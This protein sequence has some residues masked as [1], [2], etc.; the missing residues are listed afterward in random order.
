[1][2]ALGYLIILV[3]SATGGP[4][5]PEG[6]FRLGIP[7]QACMETPLPEVHLPGD[8]RPDFLGPPDA[9]RLSDDEMGK[10]KGSLGVPI[11]V[12]YPLPFHGQYGREAAPHCFCGCR[13]PASQLRS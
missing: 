3:L 10:D 9:Q 1:M 11:P 4:A 7:H 2:I 6:P 12:N 5:L 13:I 8:P